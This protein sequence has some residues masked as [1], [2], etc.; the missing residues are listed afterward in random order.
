M[1]LLTIAQ[2][3]AKDVGLAVP[4]Q[5]VGSSNRSMIEVLSFANAVGEELARRVDWMQLS[6]SATLT[7]T[8]A[9]IAHA[10][11]GSFSRLVPGVAVTGSGGEIVRP[12]SRAE[13]GTL[14]PV[15]GVPRYFLLQND[16]L[17]LWPYLAAGDTVTVW[18]QSRYW[19]YV[20][21]ALIGSGDSFG[22]DADTPLIDEGLFLKALIVR[23][24]RQKGMEYADQEAEYEAALSDLARFNDRSRI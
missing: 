15:E 7:G 24:R 6:K 22:S 2:G 3:L 18:Y 13:W 14:T 5:V 9:Q 19:G 8:G 17:T 23:W 4:D 20:N 10:M 16:T 12:L 11:P 21:P 1:T